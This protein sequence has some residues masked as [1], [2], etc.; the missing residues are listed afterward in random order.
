MRRVRDYT[1]ADDF[2]FPLTENICKRRGIAS[3][4]VTDLFTAVCE[5]C[6]ATLDGN[7]LAMSAAMIVS[8]GRPNMDACP[9]CAS[10]RFLGTVVGLNSEEQQTLLN[11][12]FF[13][14]LENPDR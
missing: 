2:I 14:T 6:G 10:K 11:D 9:K 5:G 4:S 3:K 12:K 13:K 7:A 1:K 8:A